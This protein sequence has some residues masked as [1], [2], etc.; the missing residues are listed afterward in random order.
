MK[1]YIYCFINYDVKRIVAETKAVGDTNWFRV[2][3]TAA[4]LSTRADGKEA[5]L[6]FNNSLNAALAQFQI[7][8]HFGRL[9]SINYS[10]VWQSPTAN[11]LAHYDLF[12]EQFLGD[13]LAALVHQYLHDGTTSPELVGRAMGR[14]TLLKPRT[15]R[16][17]DDTIKEAPLL[18]TLYQDGQEYV[19]AVRARPSLERQ[20]ATRIPHPM[21]IPE[22][23]RV[24]PWMYWRVQGTTIDAELLL[25]HV[26]GELIEVAK[27]AVGRKNA[28]PTI[29][30][31]PG[32][33]PEE[34]ESRLVA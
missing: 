9:S 12:S 34:I 10:P 20:L 17:I 29:V 16:G 3:Y 2:H 23:R 26:R 1:I 19:F 11:A 22:W 8:H 31:N 5:A 18:A 27:N 13:K 14:E 7:R 33:R 30:Y 24:D 21:N 6:E 25:D 28:K 15:K 4:K 32:M